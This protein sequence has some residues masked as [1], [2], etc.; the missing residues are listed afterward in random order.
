M[1]RYTALFILL[2]LLAITPASL[3][4]TAIAASAYQYIF[5]VGAAYILAA[6]LTLFVYSGRL[7]SSRLTIASVG[8]SSVPYV[9]LLV[10]PVQKVQ[11]DG[12][13]TFDYQSVIR[14]IP[15]LTRLDPP[16]RELYE[17]ARFGAPLSKTEF[18]HLMTAVHHAT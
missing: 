18:N 15:N 3:I 11:H 17:R 10:R 5:V 4:Y 8:N 2:V 1:L 12:W 13:D 7:Y 6:I 9:K 14:E 16:L